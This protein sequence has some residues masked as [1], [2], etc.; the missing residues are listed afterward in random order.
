MTEELPQHHYSQSCTFEGI[1]MCECAGR[2]DGS[3]RKLLKEIYGALIQALYFRGPEFKPGYAY[4]LTLALTEQEMDPEEEGIGDDDEE[5][6]EGHD[7]FG[8]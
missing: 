7:L 6:E 5:Q 8:D 1:E 3:D 4:T 2:D